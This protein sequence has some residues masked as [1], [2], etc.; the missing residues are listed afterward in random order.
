[1]SNYYKNELQRLEL[2]EY[3]ASVVIYDGQGNKTKQLDLN[4]ESITELLVFFEKVLTK[5]AS[6][7]SK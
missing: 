7:G 1:M 2:G 5:Q 3:P 4:R 6:E